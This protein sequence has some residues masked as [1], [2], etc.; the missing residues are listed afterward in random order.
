M[1]TYV[2][3]N[4][5]RF[6][7]ALF[8]CTTIVAAN[9]V[10][11]AADDFSEDVPVRGGLAAIADAIGISESPEAARFAA[12]FPRIV[13]N[14]AEGDTTAPRPRRLLAYFRS[15]P[16][17]AS[18]PPADLVPVPLT[19]G[20]WSDV[21]FRRPIAPE[22]L[23]EEIL[24]NRA[25][26]LLCRGL[27][28]LDDET[29]TFLTA[30]P[31]VLRHIYERDA[32]AFAGFADTLRISRGQ[33]VLPGGDQAAPLWEAVVGAPASRPEAFIGELL[34]REK[35]RVAFLFATLA[36]LDEPHRLFALGTSLPPAS[37]V[38]RFKALAA[39]TATMC[40]E[41]DVRQRPFMRPTYDVSLLLEIVRVRGDGAP[42]AP[43]SRQ[44]W[45]RAFAAGE[46]SSSITGNDPFDAA[47]LA[48]QVVTDLRVD[49][50][51]HFEQ[52]AF[53]QRLLAGIANL[54]DGVDVVIAYKRYPMLMLALERAGIRRLASFTAAAAHAQKL[55]ADSDR[56]IVAL[57]E[58]Q[59][60]IAL[61]TR[62][63]RVG[64]ISPT[65]AGD[66]VERLSAVPLN[67]G[68]YA[69][70]VAGWVRD[71]LLAVLHGTAEK[72]DE[73]IES[74][75]AGPS[76]H[77]PQRVVWEDQTYRV[78][79]AEPER[80]RLHATREQLNDR[81]VARALELYTQLPAEA[82]RRSSK[83]AAQARQV[84]DELAA[85]LRTLAYAAEIGDPDGT[86]FF[87][88][89]VGA[90]H[91][92]GVSNHD[93]A[94]QAQER[95]AE[96]H[97]DFVAGQPWH[98]AGS[99]LNLDL[100]FAT[101]VLRRI[102][103]GHPVQPVMNSNERDAFA[104]SVA[105]MNPRAL[106][107]G[108]LDVV[109]AAIAKGRAA[110]SS[111]RQSDAALDQ[112]A[113]AIGVDG[114]RRRALRWSQAHGNDPLTFFSLAELLAAGSAG[115][116]LALDAWGMTARQIDGCVCTRLY[117]PPAWTMFE[118]RAQFGLL[119]TQT[120]D[121]NLAVALALHARRLPA[122]LARDVLA[123]AAQDYIDQAR[124][125]DDG[126]WLAMVRA[127]QTIDSNKFDDYVAALTAGGPL[128]VDRTTAKPPA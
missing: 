91:D 85:A 87:G 104:K 110:I 58:F 61:I 103:T 9:A 19:V 20:F 15:L 118:G 101:L 62:A 47:W 73:I 124:P 46:G 65:T 48:R 126:D 75:L 41:W 116:P 119:A 68:E 77:D 96:P 79:L 107:D 114:W 99:I 23:I 59:G 60:S 40:P 70:G 24:S 94:G 122:V 120:A 38:E 26:A 5:R 51:D 6:A 127:A 89:D 17:D 76:P 37:R 50:Q 8:V 84:D 54:A 1:E 18:A 28:G 4:A 45:A 115:V 22:N 112:A 97:E 108:D 14:S 64:T 43:A 67:R 49:R 30:H 34:D 42:A 35:G 125:A 102:D 88:G 111:A 3:S 109:A 7:L 121:L 57:T 16:A 86:I 69:G 117:A 55:S 12:E 53:G 95:W 92:F 63:A 123:R 93:H 31:S 72:A 90:R 81:S 33:I 10:R 105:L 25:A 66:L 78:D 80:R 52:L 36:H 13:Y 128:I 11:A 29:L 21:V 56:G 74:A 71:S 113:A 2:R 82:A 27:A 106:R 100:A 32:A 83:A 39:I 98:L 44:F